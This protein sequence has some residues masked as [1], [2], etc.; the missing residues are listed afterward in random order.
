[1]NP[2]YLLFYLLAGH[3]VMDYPLQGDTTAREK[4]P[5]STTELQKHVPWYFWMIAHCFAHS[6]VVAVLTRS[7]ILTA[8]EFASHFALDYYKCRNKINIHQDQVGHMMMKVVYS[9]IFALL[10]MVPGQI[11]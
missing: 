8:C 6:V 7:V 5:G 11:F 3:F 4:N 10:D 1:M 2:A 9:Y